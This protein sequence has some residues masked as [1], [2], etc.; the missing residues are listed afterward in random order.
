MP[1]SNRATQQASGVYR[2]DPQSL[3]ILTGL[4]NLY[5]KQLPKMP[6][7]YIARLV[8][9]RNHESIAIVKRPLKVVGGITYRIFNAPAYPEPYTDKKRNETHDE[10]MARN[11]GFGEIVF[12][13]IT[14][15]EQVKGYGSHLMNNVKSWVR[16][17]YG[18][19]HFLT[20]ADN[21]A[22]GYFK[23]QG[24]TADVT[25]D[26]SAWA[27]HIKDYEGG[28]IM[29]CTMV[30]RVEYLD[31]NDV[32]AAQKRAVQERIKQLAADPATLYPGI[33]AFKDGT[34]QSPLD[35][36]AIPGLVESGW[37][38]GMERDIQESNPIYPLLRQLLGELQ[39]QSIAWPFLEPVDAELVPNY[40]DVIKE[41]MDFKTMEHRL[42]HNYYKSLNQFVHDVDL[43][44][45]NCKLF[46]DNKSVYVKCANK[47]DAVFK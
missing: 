22:V 34:Q 28:T 15:N 9:D 30:P 38:P 18:T 32:V 4:K 13:A 26:R 39:A 37:N 33:T 20:Y 12:C 3:I 29:Q 17:T 44:V 45:A 7:E 35:P 47:L 21:Y 42:D 36:F 23:K 27:G 19:Y 10:F 5:Q 25:L 6:R 8:L 2:T 1:V 14:S 41:P 16:K 43:I 31:V 46:N 24:F 40:A 11:R